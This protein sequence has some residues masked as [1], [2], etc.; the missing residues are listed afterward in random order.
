MKSNTILTDRIEYIDVFRSF[1]IILMVMGHVGF[2]EKFDLFIHAF[3]MPMFFFVSGFLFRNNSRPFFV[4]LKKKAKSLLLPYI[5]FAAFHFMLSSILNGGFSLDSLKALIFPDSKLVPIAGALWFLVALFFAD[6]IYYWIS[7][8]RN[9]SIQWIAV[10]TISLFGQIIP[11]R[12][13][14]VLPF[15]LGSAFVGVGLMHIGKTLRKYEQHIVGLKVYEILFF[16]LLVGFSILKSDYVNMRTG[17]YPDAFILFW[18]NAV[19]ASIIG[20]NIAMRFEKLLKNCI[21][22][23]YFQSIGRNS[24]VYVCSNQVVILCGFE[25]FRRFFASVSL[26]SNMVMIKNVV[27]LAFSL[28]VLFLL[29]LLFEKTILRVVIGRFKKG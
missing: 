3:H 8:I 15:A 13:G 27:V 9:S 1:G 12:F 16:G 19:C 25:L 14:L 2:G 26:P 7:R 6:M 22:S 24:I 20:L 18:I 17:A 11:E 29:S 23:K 21:I 10:C 4:C 28:V 5:V